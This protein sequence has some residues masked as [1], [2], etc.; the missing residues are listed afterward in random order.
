MNIEY[1]KELLDCQEKGLKKQAAQA[2]RQFISSFE[3]DAEK[4]DWVWS[5]LENLKENPS[6]KIR[7]EL[8]QELI[9]PVL[10]EGYKHN[11]ISAIFWL[12]AINYNDDLIKESPFD[13]LKRYLELDPNDNKARKLMLTRIVDWL[14]YCIHEWPCGIL[15]NNDAAN[16]EQCQEMRDDIAFGK[17]LDK[18]N[19]FSELF[20]DVA[21]K[22][23]EYEARLV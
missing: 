14:S 8:W 7:Y 18:E 11:N 9:I 2:V 12:S 6:L 19:K 1:F 16:L 4:A 15:Y 23:H 20:E 10:I 13:M 17:S 22:L 5:I 3:N 21:K